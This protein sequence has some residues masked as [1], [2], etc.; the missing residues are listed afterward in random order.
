MDSGAKALRRVVCVCGVLVWSGFA[1]A[2]PACN[3]PK[4]FWMQESD[5]RKEL[6]QQGY[7]VKTIRVQQGC[8]EIYG[9]DPYGR[10]VQILV[11]PATSKPIPRQFIPNGD[12]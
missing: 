3:V 11:D 6:R 8:Y 12:E 2:Q 4:D 5:L 10:R 7:L 1:A 9:L